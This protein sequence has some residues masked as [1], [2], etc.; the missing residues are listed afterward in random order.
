MAILQQAADAHRASAAERELSLDVGPLSVDR[1]VLAD[2]ER[3]QLVLGNLVQNA[4]RHTPSGGHVELRA[5]PEADALRF[6]VSD[7]G[8]GIA[9]EHLPR[10]FERFSRVPG[11]IPG[12]AGLGLFICKEIVEAHGGKV[13]VESEVGHGS[14]FWFTLPLAALEVNT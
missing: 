2:P 4:L 14:I 9:A 11:G 13:G 6:Q 10:L 8:P 3:I 7:T 5:A 1:Q 12:G